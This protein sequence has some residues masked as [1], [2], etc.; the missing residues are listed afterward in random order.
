[1]FLATPKVRPVGERLVLTFTLPGENEPI[2]VETEVRWVRAS[3]ADAQ[4]EEPPGM[5]LRFVNLAFELPSVLQR[6]LTERE[7]EAERRARA[8]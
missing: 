8:S 6:F 2:A 1:M 5:G 3:A 7:R 4:V